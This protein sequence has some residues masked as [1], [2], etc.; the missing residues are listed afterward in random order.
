M[1]HFLYQPFTVQCACSVLI[2]CLRVAYLFL[3][4]NDYVTTNIHDLRFSCWFILH[5][6]PIDPSEAARVRQSN[7][8]MDHIPTRAWVYS[9]WWYHTRVAQ[10]LQLNVDRTFGQGYCWSILQVRAPRESERRASLSDTSPQFLLT[11]LAF[12]CYKPY[13]CS[14]PNDSIA[15]LPWMLVCVRQRRCAQGLRHCNADTAI[16]FPYGEIKACML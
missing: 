10:Q 3:D 15:L 4:W 11:R 8:I 16:S 1:S 2:T 7:S 6:A 12:S 14:A 9:L 13:T 5:A